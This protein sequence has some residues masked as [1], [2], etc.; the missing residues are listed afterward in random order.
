[1]RWLALIVAIGLG[2]CAH[3]G[4]LDAS[5]GR[6]RYIADLEQ[7]VLAVGPAVVTH[8]GTQGDGTLFL[9]SAPARTGTDD[10]CV[11]SDVEM[12]PYF[13]I[14]AGAGREV[15]LSVAPGEV[16]CA[17]VAMGMGVDVT[18][19]VVPSTASASSR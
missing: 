2:G 15:S 6:A 10:D 12:Q 17:A 11:V 13:P 9:Y 14:E 7:K 16:E 19:I 5:R 18:W 4:A 1:M 3:S 8:V